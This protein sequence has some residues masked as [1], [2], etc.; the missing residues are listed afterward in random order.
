MNAVEKLAMDLRD[1]LRLS[2]QGLVDLYQDKQS[3][4]VFNLVRRPA[5]L[6]H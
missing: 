5:C 3:S 2:N 4:S 1:A 6:V